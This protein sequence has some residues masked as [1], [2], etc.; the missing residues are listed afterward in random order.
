MTWTYGYSDG[1]ATFEIVDH[2]GSTVYEETVNGRALEQPRQKCLD[3]MLNEAMTSYQN[4]GMN[5]RTFAIVRDAMFEQI[6]DQT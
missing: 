6:S 3:V 5:A 1:G 2:S 4:N